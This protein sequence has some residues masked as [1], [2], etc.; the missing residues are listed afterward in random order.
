MT[1]PLHRDPFG[2]DPGPTVTIVGGLM[3]LIDSRQSI[4]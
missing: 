4:V 1:G 3:R 2:G